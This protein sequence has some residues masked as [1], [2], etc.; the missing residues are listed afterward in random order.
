MK[1]KI[2]YN[3]ENINYATIEGVALG[4]IHR[5]LEEDKFLRV[6]V[7]FPP[8]PDKDKISYGKQMLIRIDEISAIMSADN[9]PSFPKIL[10]D[11][12]RPKVRL[13]PKLDDDIDMSHLAEQAREA[14]G[15]DQP[16][17]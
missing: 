8:G 5:R 7:H 12:D 9:D 13:T 1:I 2:I 16:V 10:E 15:Y 14:Q 17:R 3:D 11:R 4:D 6:V